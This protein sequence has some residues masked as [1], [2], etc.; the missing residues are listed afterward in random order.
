MITL[1]R[2]NLIHQLYTLCKT[3][4]IEICG[5]QNNV[6]ESHLCVHT[7]ISTW[8]LFGNLLLVWACSYNLSISIIHVSC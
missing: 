5:L 1:Y 2:L 4:N 8:S 3:Q 7:G 6:I